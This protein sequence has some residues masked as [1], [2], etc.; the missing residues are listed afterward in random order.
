MAIARAPSGLN[1]G[2]TG[3]K[4]D[5]STRLALR[6]VERHRLIRGARARERPGQHPDSAQRAA[7]TPLDRGEP[8][9]RARPLWRHGSG[10]IESTG[11]RWPTADQTNSRDRSGAESQS[12]GGMHASRQRPPCRTCA[13]G[14]SVA[15]ATT[16]G[17][18]G[19][20]EVHTN[21]QKSVTPSLDKRRTRR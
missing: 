10:D 4:R 17:R 2:C 7:Y 19:H 9:N 18:T 1:H 20:T 14:W 16:V 5:R 8:E 11:R 6:W 12:D 15:A 13:I 21:A 3:I